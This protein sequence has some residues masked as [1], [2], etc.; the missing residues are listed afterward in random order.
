MKI[1]AISSRIPAAGR[2]GDQVVS[3]FRLM[4]LAQTHDVELVCFGDPAKPED[5]DALQVLERAGIVVH[6]VPWKPWIALAHMLL[7]I[8]NPRMPFQCAFFRSAAFR[9]VLDAVHARFQPDALYCVMIRILPNL[10]AYPQPMFVDMV[11]SMGLNFS[12]RL[13]AARGIKK[14][15]LGL[16]FDRIRDYERQAGRRAA[17]SFV[18][19]EFDRN[20]I[21]LDNV[22]VLPLGIDVTHFRQTH[23]FDQQP[24]VVFSGNMSYQPNVEAV[25][26]FVKH[27]WQA[28]RTALPDARLVIAGGNPASAISALAADGSITVTGRV[29]SM[30][31]AINGSR[32]AVAPMQSGSGMQF[33]VLEAMACAVPV[34]TTTV[35][36]GDIKAVPGEQVLV[37]DTSGKVVELVVKLLQDQE[38]RRKIG[39]AGMN[40]V[41]ANHQWDVINRQFSAI[42]RL[43]P[44]ESLPR[45]SAAIRSPHPLVGEGRGRG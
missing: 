40:Y 13:Q 45:Q 11:D 43:D 14:L 10:G 8:P 9:R 27:C 29:P 19:S 21:G 2:K 30:A 24:I 31:D 39:L 17:A 37:G 25:L 28:V 3:F 20:F 23:A 15:L 18:V 34:V 32:V 42:C 26:W 44:L 36:L 1:L 35:G 7:A 22:H 6:L 33:K 5:R 38:L 41:L 4:Q 16:E 12:R